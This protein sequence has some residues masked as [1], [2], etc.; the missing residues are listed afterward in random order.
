MRPRAAI[1]RV[2]PRVS[3][4]VVSA[5]IELKNG[6]ERYG[7]ALLF[8]ALLALAGLVAERSALQKV[9][10]FGGDV[11]AIER[12]RLLAQRAAYLATASY[13]DGTSSDERNTFVERLDATRTLLLDAHERLMTEPAVTSMEAAPAVRA[14]FLEPPL[15]VDRRLRRFIATLDDWKQV[16]VSEPD[17]QPSQAVLQTELDELVDG[18]DAVGRLYR[19][20]M[21]GELGM[22]DRIILTVSI[23]VL[24][25][26][27]L[28]GIYV[29]RPIVERLQ[30]EHADLQKTYR[31]LL[32]EMAERYQVIRE[33]T[34]AELRFRNAFENA[35]IGMGLMHSDGRLFDANPALC[36]RFRASVDDRQFNFS[37]VFTGPDNGRFK[38][39]VELV[40]DTREVRSRKLHCCDVDGDEMVAIISLS[41][42]SEKGHGIDYMV[43]QVEDITESH[44]LHSKLQYQASYDELT[45]LM[46][47]RAFNREVTE[48]WNTATPGDI[49]NYLLMMDLDQFKIINDTSGHAAGDQLLRRV[50]EIIKECVRSNDLVCRLGGDEFGIVLLHCPLEVA[51]RIAESIRTSISELRFSWGNENYRIGVSVGIVA[52]DPSL[53]DVSEIQQLADSACY[54]AKEAGRNNVQVV[55][56]GRSDAR[57]HRRQIRWVQRIRDAM[58]NNRFAI[59]GQPIVPTEETPGAPGRIEILLRLRDP[60]ERRMIPPGAFLPAAERYGLNIELD[61]W[62]VSRLIHMLYAHEQ[63]NA[64]E[65]RYWINLSG[66]SVGDER[67]AEVLKDLVRQSPLKPGT[68]NFEITE[69]AVIR[70]IASAGSLMTELRSMGCQI[71]LDDFGSGLSSFGYLK[72]LPIDYLKIDGMFVR[73]IEHDPTNRI[74]VKSI[75]DI[76]H[77]LDI[78]TVAEFVENGNIA[79]I[80]TDLGA[81]Y[82]QG[83]ALGKPTVLAPRFPPLEDQPER[84]IVSISQ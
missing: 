59:Y 24:A 7:L 4:V 36:S 81:D 15:Q 28:L 31:K 46:N 10:A 61:Q 56:E 22:L 9:D 75:I 66:N 78:K 50:A 44:S 23:G 34:A 52:I 38:D 39:L 80:V 64:G 13:R 14:A 53:G 49:G 68:L 77:S 8:V 30:V 65:M 58:D 82:L 18:L 55:A 40:L 2:E 20:E 48:A 74:F 41:P 76:A 11:E 33:R 51:Q 26:L 6:H 42:V 47:R 60:D 67:F 84:R 71:A 69:T 57:Y 83:Y 3:G 21:A 32:D 62:V 27:L 70:N 12:Q 45:G 16:R 37:D 17:G 19:E 5:K 79:K 63:F 29:F 72:H 25:S 54:A 35:P 1:C 43:L 73:D